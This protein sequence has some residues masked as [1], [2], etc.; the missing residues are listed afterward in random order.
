MKQV[1][2]LFV[3]LFISVS[4]AQLSVGNV[5]LDFGEDISAVDGSILR[6]AGV[7]NGVIYALA[8]EKKKFLLQTF[9]ASSKKNTGSISLKLDKLEN[10]KIQIEDIVVIGQRVYVMASYYVK[11]D[12]R[13]KFVALEVSE[14][15]SLGKPITL[16]SVE[17]P[18]RK[19]S[20]VFLYEPSY[21]EFNYMVAH[22]GIIE[23]KELL[24]YEFSLLDEGMNSVASAKHTE[25]FEDRKDLQFDF[26]DFGVNQKGDVFIVLSDS[27]R[28]KKSKTTRN[29]ISL[30]TYYANQ[31]YKKDIVQV[32]L[33]GKK[34]LNCDLTYTQDNNVQLVGFYSK[35][36]NSGKAKF[37][38]EG[39]FD[40]SI[41]AS[42]NSVNK[43]TFNDFTFETKKK[44][45][46][47]RRAS[48]D[49]D[50]KPFYRNTD[51]IERDGGGII[52]LSEYFQTI[53]G[54]S[55]GLSI[56][57][58][59]I[60][61]TPVTYRTNEIIVTALNADG[62][63]AWSNV[64]PKEQ[65]LSISI[66]S[67]GLV[68]GASNGNVAVSAGIM[69]PV[70]TLG[71]GPEYLSS[72]PLYTEG[73]LTVIVND[74]PKNMG[75]TEIDDMKKVKNINKMIPVAFEF[76]DATG[77]MTRVD[78]E[79]FEKKQ[80]VI[81]PGVYHSISNEQYIIYGS[82]KSETRLGVLTIE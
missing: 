45:I 38:L 76:D 56:A 14:D 33:Q 29:R 49:K 7:R 13:N 71:D 26:S 6:I 61:A 20:G 12:K 69:F 1:T 52:V 44:L 35:L 11:S 18:N 65:Q 9:E 72:V 67:V 59:G 78:P 3:L 32:D 31:E 36:K 58:V 17:V 24:N 27:Y 8:K 2:L 57:G 39:I 62:T 28:D 25:N 77:A 81:R 30:H 37:S 47:E 63:L 50:L 19:N 66:V 23:K 51:F 43:K 64:I 46:G 10:S 82:N 68:L 60:A 22:V 75:I 53:Y 34:V 48:K 42:D 21:D 70:G 73:K 80:I 74:D 16:L 54:Q 55:S 5:S 41:N 4:Q 15:L 40:I 79:D